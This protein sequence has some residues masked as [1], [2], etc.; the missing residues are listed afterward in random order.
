MILMWISGVKGDCLIPGFSDHF[1]CTSASFSITREVAE[2][3]KAGTADLVFGVGQ[4]EDLSIG[5]TMDRGSPELAKYAMR[6]AT[7]G[8]VDIKFVETTTDNNEP[9]NF[10]FLW[11]KLD[12]AFAKT[13]SINGSDDGRPEEELTLW[14]NKIAFRWYYMGVNNAPTASSEFLWDHVKNREWP[15]AEAKLPTADKAFVKDK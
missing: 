14:Y 11:I 5:K 13:W 9:V 7:L 1:T 15:S 8:T 12:K 3:A 6:G 10:I 4:L 2:S